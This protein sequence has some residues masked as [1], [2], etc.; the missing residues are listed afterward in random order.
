[1]AKISTIVEGLEDEIEKLKKQ[2]QEERAAGKKYALRHLNTK[3]KG[4]LD[5]TA[6]ILQ[7]GGVGGATSYELADHIWDMMKDFAKE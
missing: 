4:F 7:E 5:G 1:M 3:T 6:R 2:V